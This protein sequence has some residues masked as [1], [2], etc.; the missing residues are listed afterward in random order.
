MEPAPSYPH[1][2]R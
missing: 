2:S 1:F